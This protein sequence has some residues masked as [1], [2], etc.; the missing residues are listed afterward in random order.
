MPDLLTLAVLALVGARLASSAHHVA[1]TQAARRRI[2]EIAR[3]L[4]L[5]H[6]VL[7][8]PVLAAVLVVATVLIRVPVLS[9]GWWTALGGQGNPVV[10]STSRT[11]GTAAAWLIPAVFL[12]LLIP[13]LPLFAE[14][15]E[16]MFR[17]GAEHW[18]WQRRVY[19]CLQFGLVHALIGIPIGVAIALSIGGA[20]FMTAYV[21]TY[22][23]SGEHAA[24]MESTRCH[25]AYNAT[26]CVLVIVYLV[27]LATG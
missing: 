21:R 27:S 17:Q 2:V 24:L 8:P 23:R 12:V 11:A 10:G 20:Y 15:E 5:H 7:V 26:I 14:R 6:F 4:R 22:R 1:T 18:S 16:V 3:G 9:F 13:V 19:K 25:L